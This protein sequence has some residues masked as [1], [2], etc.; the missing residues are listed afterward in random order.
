VTLGYTGTSLSSVTA[1]GGRSLTITV[2]GQERI[3]AIAGL[4]GL[5]T[6]YTYTAAGDLATAT[7]AAGAVTTYTY[8]ARHQLLTVVDGL[9]RTV[10]TNTYGSLGRVTQQ[11]DAKQEV[12]ADISPDD[13]LAARAALAEGAAGAVGQG[14]GG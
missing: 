14:L 5:G 13:R 12:A 11:R 3:T 9:S 2:S 6:S 8:D 1:A 7:N 4:G 10:T